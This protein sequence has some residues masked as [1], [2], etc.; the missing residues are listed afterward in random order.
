MNC[1]HFSISLG[2]YTT[3]VSEFLP[4]VMLWIAFIFQYLW[5]ITQLNQVGYDSSIGCELLSF[6]NIF[7]ILHNRKYC[8]YSRGYVVN[9]FHFSISLGYYTTIGHGHCTIITLWI[10]FIFQYLWDITQHVF[11]TVYYK[12]RCELLSFFNIFGILHNQI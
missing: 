7:G 6:F 12:T 11:N 9:C 8:D 2:Y 3:N 5:D 4:V 10:A 1:F